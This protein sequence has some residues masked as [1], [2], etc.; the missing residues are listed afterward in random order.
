[1]RHVGTWDVQQARGRPDAVEACASERKASHVCSGD[2]CTN[3]VR[4][5]RHLLGRV[6]RHHVETGRAKVRRVASGPA[7]EICDSS[8]RAHRRDEA[9][10]ELGDFDGYRRVASHEVVDDVV[11]GIRRRANIVCGH[12]TENAIT[13]VGTL[14]RGRSRRLAV[15]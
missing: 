2:R 1:L 13:T 7:A 3:A 5:E 8:A 15:P 4:P 14:S 12:V 9:D 6:Y 10:P 11:L